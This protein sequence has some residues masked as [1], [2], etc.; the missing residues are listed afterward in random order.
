MKRWLIVLLAALGAAG[1]LALG[2]WQLERRVWKLALIERVE[3]RVHAEPAAAPGPSQWPG[4]NKENAEYLRV[5]VN[6]R[7][8]AGRATLVQAVTDLGAGF[9]VMAPLQADEGFVVYINR[10]FVPT[11]QRDSALRA[12]PGGTE[13]KVSITGLLRLTE[14]RGGFLRSNA[15]AENRWY[16]RD[17]AAISQAQGIS[18]AAP[19]FIDA[20]TA[21]TP[22]APGQPV[23]GLTVIAFHNSHLV[24]ALTWYALALMVAIG[25][26]YAVREERRA[27]RRRLS[28]R[29]GENASSA[30]GDDPDAAPHP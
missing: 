21:S 2:V 24:Y 13:E 9:W 18:G 23:G 27:A 7:F 29:H 12:Q 14:P 6:G 30:P 8:I 17:V 10:G 3:H 1:F 4:L 28:A 5:R 20:N 11:E 22:A 25:A 26:G 16:S 15:P 19:Y